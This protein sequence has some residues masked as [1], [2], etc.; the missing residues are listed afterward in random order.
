MIRPSGGHASPADSLSDRS[1]GL[2]GA[3]TV[4]IPGVSADHAQP[5]VTIGVI[6]FNRLHYL[7]ALIDSAR[8]CIDYPNL[9]WVIVDGSSTEPGLREYLADLDFADSVD[10]VPSGLLA[11]SMNKL[12]ERTRGEYLLMVPDRMQFIVRG[13]WLFDVVEFLDRTPGAGHVCYDAQRRLTIDEQFLEAYVR[14]RGR[15]LP[16]RAWRRPF[17]RRRTTSGLEFLGYG[18]TMPGINVGSVSLCRTEILRDLGPWRTTMELQLSNDAGLGTETD[19]LQRYRRS[20]L[21]LERFLMGLP[22]AASTVTDPRGTAA[23]IRHGNRR[24]GHYMPP[25]NGRFYYRIHEMED[26]RR[27]FA[28]CHP[29]PAF[30]DIVEPLGWP[31]PLDDNGDLRKVSVIREDEPYELV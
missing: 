26:A 16:L 8:E 24:Y 14:A 4:R 18:R 13:P 23:K 25:P 15:R 17:K 3:L 20:G 22:V 30:E 28:T 10:F 6:S 21:K 11:D 2:P 12:M 27:A 7:R 5:L 9:Q 31:L 19:M 1:A 29:A